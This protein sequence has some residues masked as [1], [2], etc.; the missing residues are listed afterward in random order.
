M[1][2]QGP[3]IAD[4]AAARNQKIAAE[5]KTREDTDR[6]AAEL[7][8]AH[9]DALALKDKLRREEG[10]AA[11]PQQQVWDSVVCAFWGQSACQLDLYT[12]MIEATAAGMSLGACIHATMHGENLQQQSAARLAPTLCSAPLVGAN[13]MV[14]VHDTLC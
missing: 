2:D 12:H 14:L 6:I 7:E 13:R 9:Q 1:S 5:H 8:G 10:D 4:I 3:S 11:V